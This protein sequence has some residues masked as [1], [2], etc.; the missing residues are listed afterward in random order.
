MDERRR[1]RAGIAERQPHELSGGQRQRVALAR[2]LALRP[3]LLIADEP[4]SALDVS[5]QAAVLAEFARLQA[6]LGFACVFI[7]HDLAVVDSVSDQVLVLHDGRAVES[8]PT[9]TVLGNPS[10]QY[11]RALLAAVP[12]PD[13]IEQRARH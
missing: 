5:V 6:E 10:H 12:I 7:S 3:D 8:G 9:A 1:C 11:T 2:A 13:P 4:T